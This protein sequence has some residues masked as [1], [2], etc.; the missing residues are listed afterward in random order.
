MLGARRF[1]NRPKQEERT[2][3]EQQGNSSG[4]S[5]KYGLK[6]V[7]NFNIFK[8]NIQESCCFTFIL[9]NPAVLDIDDHNSRDLDDDKEDGED[10]VSGHEANRLLLCPTESK[11]GN[12]QGHSTNT[13]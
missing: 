2:Q 6:S 13:N 9:L 5:K 3:Q 1:L 4:S 8:V 10:D 12:Q 11:K 7:R